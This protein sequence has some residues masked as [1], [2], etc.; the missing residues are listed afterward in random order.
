MIPLGRHSLVSALAA[1]GASITNSINRI[2]AI[3]LKIV[4]VFMKV[5]FSW[6]PVNFG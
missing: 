6:T 1:V 4:S 5:V 3:F 2:T